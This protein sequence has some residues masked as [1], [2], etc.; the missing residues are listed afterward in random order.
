MKR[1]W[2]I[3]ISAGGCLLVVVLFCAG[4]PLIGFL[5]SADKIHPAIY[6]DNATPDPVTVEFDGEDWGTVA[7]GAYQKFDGRR[8]K[9]GNHTIVVRN[10]A[11]RNEL[12]RRTESIDDYGPFVLN[13]QGAQTYLKVSDYDFQAK[14]KFDIEDGH[15]QR[16]FRADGFDIAAASPA[17]GLFYYGPNST[18]LLRW[19]QIPDSRKAKSAKAEDH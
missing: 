6:V 2:I 19:S 8:M 14:D 12:E 7:S 10:A 15:Q 9:R 11:D 17:F 1:S 4:L 3:G 5:S 16:W 13:V 18:R